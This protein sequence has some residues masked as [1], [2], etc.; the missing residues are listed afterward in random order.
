MA[1]LHNLG[2]TTA[3]STLAFS[4]HIRKADRI[5]KRR[6]SHAAL[7]TA[8]ETALESALETGRLWSS[9]GANAATYRGLLQVRSM[10]HLDQL[11]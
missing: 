5:D 3:Q 6:A 4:V 9:V 10:Q 1:K 7:E 11:L 8:L 2:W